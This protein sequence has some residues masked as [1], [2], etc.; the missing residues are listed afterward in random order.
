MLKG[1]SFLAATFNSFIWNRFWSFE[2]HG[3]E[4]IGKEALQFYAVTIVGLLINVGIA[5]GMKAV[6]P[7]TTLWVGVVSPGI[8]TIFSL[9]W[10]F[11]GY[12]FFVFKKKP[13]TPSAV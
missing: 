3:K 2:E 6:G 9:A 8:A 12:K 11:V 5:T 13:S 7:D 10:N 4:K 1:F